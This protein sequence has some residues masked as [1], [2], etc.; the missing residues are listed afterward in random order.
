MKRKRKSLSE[1]YLL[2]SYWESTLAPGWYY[3]RTCTEAESPYK[4]P[5]L[6]TEPADA[7]RN[8]GRAIDKARA[9]NGASIIQWSD[10]RGRHWLFQRHARRGVNTKFA[11]NAYGGTYEQYRQHP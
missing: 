8:L 9:V 6:Y 11:Q 7:R 3:L 5:R 1:K 10:D 2:I 4:V